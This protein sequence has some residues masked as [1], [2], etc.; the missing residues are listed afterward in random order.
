M[1]GRINEERPHLSAYLNILK[2]DDNGTYKKYQV[3]L[4]IGALAEWALSRID[5]RT[6]VAGSPG[7]TTIQW[8]PAVLIEQYFPL[9]V[10]AFNQALVRYIA[11][12]CLQSEFLPFA[13][14]SCLLFQFHHLVWLKDLLI[15]LT[16]QT[17]RRW[18]P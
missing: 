10:N 12:P 6:S 8:I 3:K 5:A 18:N 14:S 4:A 2:V 16:F 13:F 17:L 1:E 15:S 9:M 11:F 7:A